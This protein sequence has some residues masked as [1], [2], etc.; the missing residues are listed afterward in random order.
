MG[1]K[2]EVIKPAWTGKLELFADK[3][4]R[5]TAAAL[6]KNPARSGLVFYGEPTVQVTG[7]GV[8]GRNQELALRMATILPRFEKN[9][10]FL[11][12]G[13]DGIDGPTDAAGAVTDHRTRSRALERSI[14]PDTYLERND[15]Y[16]F[17]KE[18]GDHIITGPTGN[19]VMDLQI[20]L[21]E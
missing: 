16:N 6:R 21:W 17:F 10:A 1:F 12:C 15:S 14:D 20:V 8:G 13:T 3:I 11:S 4:E 7:D 18:F 9:I 5:E 2:T 19:N